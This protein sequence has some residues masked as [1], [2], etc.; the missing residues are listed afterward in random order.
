MIRDRIE[1]DEHVRY[2]DVDVPGGC[3]ITGRK[4][5]TYHTYDELSEGDEV[6]ICAGVLAGHT[7]TVVC[8]NV[9]PPNIG[10]PIYSYRCEA[11]PP[12]VESVVL[13]WSDGDEMVYPVGVLRTIHT[14]GV[15]VVI[16]HD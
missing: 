6:R 10:A 2:V 9:D 15:R 11:A 3:S 16:D 4:L 8:V 7:G 14:G 13:R 1:A 12:R 5:L